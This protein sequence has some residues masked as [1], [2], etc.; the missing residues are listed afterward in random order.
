ME[1]A[2]NKQQ[3]LMVENRSYLPAH[4][5]KGEKVAYVSR[6][7]E[8]YEAPEEKLR[9]E[10]AESPAEE[11]PTLIFNSLASEPDPLSLT[12]MECRE[13][14]ATNL[15]FTNP[16]LS[17]SEKE[18]A[19]NLLLD[20]H[21]CFSLA[22]G[23]LGHIRDIEVE[24]ETGDARPIRQNARRVAYH[25]CDDIKKEIEKLLKLSV[26]KDS[27]SPWASPIVAV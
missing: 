20:N 26:V 22:P 19:T 13:K 16:N 21:D 7:E 10:K 12:E 14:L 9:E 27:N 25:L 18:T 8:A 15:N 2:N 1:V 11:A 17:K 23:E 4:V 3:W 5:K 24:I 6:I